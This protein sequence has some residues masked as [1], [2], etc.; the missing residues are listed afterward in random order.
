MDPANGAVYAKNLST[1]ESALDAKAKEWSGLLQA[2]QGAKVVT[3]HKSFEYFAHHFGLVVAGQIEPKP[4]IEPSPTYI[5]ALIPKMKEAS[6]KLV[7]V[8]PNRSK[9]TS[10]YVAS[11]LGVKVVY[12]PI[13][14]GGN[15]EATDYIKLID[16][17]VKS[18]A[19]ALK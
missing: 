17:N 8:E 3:Y 14:V 7:M 6:V 9:K 12:L 1:F 15:E 5:N 18:A 19:K 10:E 11:S 4:G 16:Y 13:L 2:N